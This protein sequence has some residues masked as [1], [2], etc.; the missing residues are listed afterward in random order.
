MFTFRSVIYL[1]SVKCVRSVSRF[2]FLHADVQLFSTFGWGDLLYCLFYFVKDP[3]SVSGRSVLFHWSVCLFFQQYCMTL[4]TTGL[5]SFLTYV[6]S[7]MNFPLGTVFAVLQNSSSFTVVQ[8]IWKLTLRFLLW[9]VYF[10]EVCGL[11]SCVFCG[12]PLN[13][14]FKLGFRV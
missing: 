8:N 12:F 3:G 9:L 14:L 6:F 10:L 5:S 4:I 1:I 2:L 13:F 7:A 11:K